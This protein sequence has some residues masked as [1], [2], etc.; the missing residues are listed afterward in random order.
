M[1][2]ADAA[3]A[4]SLEKCAPLD[5]LARDVCRK[6][7]KAVHAAAKV[8]AKLQKEVAADNLKAERVVRD[9]DAVDQRQLDAQFAA[10]QERCGML[11]AEGRDN[12]LADAR[13]RFGKI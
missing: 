8:E 3:L 2:R 4:V 1:A 6:D 10:A 9:R 5:R 7:A 13:R 12:C 11:P